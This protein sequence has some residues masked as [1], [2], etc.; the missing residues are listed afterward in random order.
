MAKDIIQLHSEILLLKDGSHTFQLLLCRSVVGN[1][2]TTAGQKSVV[3]F[4]IGC[5]HN[6]SKGSFKDINLYYVFVVVVVCLFVFLWRPG[7]RI[8]IGV[9]CLSLVKI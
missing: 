4:V 7:I 6:S 5:T 2:F 3:I 8:R 9:G 1:L